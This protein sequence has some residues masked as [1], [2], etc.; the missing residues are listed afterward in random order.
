ML[1]QWIENCV[2]Q[3]IG[4][5]EGLVLDF[6]DYNELVITAPLR[7][8]LPA[9]GDFT[10]EELLI[11]PRSVPGIER[12]VLDFSGKLCT[13]ASVDDDG[14]LQVEF[15]DGHVIEVAPNSERVAWELYGKRPRVRSLARS[16]D[17]TSRPAPARSCRRSSPAAS[18]RGTRSRSRSSAP[19]WPSQRPPPACGTGPTW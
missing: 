16:F 1:T 19:R 5:R 18:R 7:L 3:R 12:A 15:A 4:L 8:T 9:L 6:E 2:V 13:R 14:T 10:A 11:D 17:T